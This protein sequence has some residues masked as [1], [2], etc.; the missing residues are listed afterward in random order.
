MRC[1]VRIVAVSPFDAEKYHA[2]GRYGIILTLEDSTAR[3]HASLDGLDGV[4]LQIIYCNKSK[5]IL[6]LQIKTF[7]FD[8]Y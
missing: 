4:M 3:I 2:D 7:H 5:E 6:T 1:V 8:L